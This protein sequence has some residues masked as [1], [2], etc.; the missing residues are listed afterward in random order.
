[1]NVPGGSK[2]YFYLSYLYASAYWERKDTR[3]EEECV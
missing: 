1:M 3:G 2:T